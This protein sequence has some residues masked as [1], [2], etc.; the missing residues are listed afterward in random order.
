MSVHDQSKKPE[1][2]EEE[3]EEE[4]DEPSQQTT[5]PGHLPS[6][7]LPA[8]YKPTLI[9]NDCEDV[10]Q[11]QYTEFLDNA[12]DYLLTYIKQHCKPRPC[13]TVKA[14]LLQ[15]T[16]TDFAIA[17]FDELVK[18]LVIACLEHPQWRPPD[19]NNIN[20][21]FYIGATH[22]AWMNGQDFQSSP[23]P[24]STNPPSKEK[25]VIPEQGIKMLPKPST[26][27]P[28]EEAQLT[29]VLQLLMTMQ[30]KL[31]KLEDQQSPIKGSPSSEAPEYPDATAEKPKTQDDI[32]KE[33]IHTLKV[34]Q[35]EEASSGPPP[36]KVFPKHVCEALL[37]L[38]QYPNATYKQQAISHAAQALLQLYEMGLDLQP[39]GTFHKVA[40]QITVTAQK[41]LAADAFPQS[42]RPLQK[43]KRSLLKTCLGNTLTSLELKEAYTGPS[44]N[45]ARPTFSKGRSNWK[46]NYWR[47]SQ[48]PKPFPGGRGGGRGY[49]PGRGRGRPPGDPNIH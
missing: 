14:W 29:T 46:E 42:D 49:N 30:T 37:D 22:D 44:T 32:N 39:T 28:P 43:E 34:L 21:H 19:C 9:L 20:L 1:E 41:A 10:F 45:P 27:T 2:E 38:Y 31:K 24:G 16:V 23:T 3:E 25:E 40:H 36:L 7:H 6:A 18:F 8:V 4:D 35:G 12:K 17:G 15:N 26:S 5:I 13:A 48:S 47:G 11:E 33:L